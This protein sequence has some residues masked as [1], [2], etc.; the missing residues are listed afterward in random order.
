MAPR[1]TVSSVWS[2]C[3]TTSK[4]WLLCA[5]LGSQQ[6]VRKL[7]SSFSFPRGSWHLGRQREK[8]SESSRSHRWQAGTVPMQSRDAEASAPSQRS[9]PRCPRALEKG[10]CRVLASESPSGLS[11]CEVGADGCFSGC[12]TLPPQIDLKQPF[13]F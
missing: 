8:S 5:A 9:G 2:Q 6:A 4:Q 11:S 3:G 12:T 13:S 1:Q 7:H 10:L